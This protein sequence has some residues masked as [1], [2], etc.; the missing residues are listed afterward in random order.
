M[1]LFWYWKGGIEGGRVSK[2]MVSNYDMLNTI[3]EII[4][5]KQLATSDG[6][7]YAKTLQ[8]VESESRDF[9]V[10]ASFFGPAIVTKEG[11]KLRYFA[12]EDIYQLYYL[13]DDYREE[14]ILND[15]YPAK[16]SELKAILIDE[17]DG[18]LENGLFNW[19]K[20]VAYQ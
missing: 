6:M 17:C 2:Q 10:Y 14:N 16:V 9:T 18:D 3:A 4:G 7:S 1:P 20:I 13:P 11:W 12:P 8:G 19:S 5:Q 15:D